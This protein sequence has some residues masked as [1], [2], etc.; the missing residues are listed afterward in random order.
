MSDKRPFDKILRNISKNTAIYSVGNIGIKVVSFL[1]IPLYT[2]YLSE[3]D[4]GVIGL[5]ESLEL[6]YSYLAPVGIL[7]GMWRYFYPARERNEEP[8]FVASN[9]YCLLAI[10][11][12]LLA[13]LVASAGF[14][15]KYY[16]SGVSYTRLVQWFSVA[17]FMGL[18]RQFLMTIFRLQERAFHFIILV[19]F[20]FVLLIGLTI[21]F[22]VEFELGLWGIIYAK[23]ITTAVI[24]VFTS[25]FV[26]RRYG[27]HVEI[28]QV[29]EPVR[30][31]M[32]LILHGLSLVVMTMA[33]RLLIK[34]MVS[35]EASGVYNIAAKFGMILNMVLVTPFVQAWQ[36]LM[37]KLEAD[38]HQKLTYQKIALHFTQIGVIVWVGISVVSKYI[39][40]FT[41]PEP[42]HYG[43]VIIPWIALAYFM[44]G[45]QQVFRAGALLHNRTVGLTKRGMV[46]A[47]CNIAL[48]LWMIRVW[49]IVGASLA[50]T[51]SYFIL[52]MLTLSLSQSVLPITWRWRKMTSVFLLGV[53]FVVISLFE[54]DTPALN[55]LKDVLTLL[56]A[57]ALMI[58]L[59]LISFSELKRFVENFRSGSAAVS[60]PE[61]L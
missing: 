46:A 26:I 3:S 27:I 13:A 36:P 15:A 23:L 16:L 20:N 51:L 21:L 47:A 42:Y 48:N 40:R 17:L 53:V 59:N 29:R 41:S 24:F 37:F 8:R 7:S 35:I 31:G 18:S 14:I 10:N 44:Y 45:L 60:Q 38:P 1:L 4:V 52:M 6:F 54:L 49:G 5:L 19:F 34:E 39:L 50:A 30:Y 2:N 56:G 43:V 9:Y 25:G 12:V 61:R 33:D 11:T 28:D 55:Y 22:V 57:P 58:L 32:P